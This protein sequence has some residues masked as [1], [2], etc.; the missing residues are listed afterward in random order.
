MPA[1][2]REVLVNPGIISFL[3]IYIESFIQFQGNAVNSIL[4]LCDIHFG[5]ATVN[6]NLLESGMTQRVIHFG[7]ISSSFGCCSGLMHI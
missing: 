5:F 6:C 4:P 1:A 2:L 7:L 3:A